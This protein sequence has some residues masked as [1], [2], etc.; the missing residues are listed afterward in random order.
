MKLEELKRKRKEFLDDTLKYYVKDPSRRAIVIA[1]KKIR[2][3]YKTTDGRKCAIGRHIAED[4]YD[5]TIEG[6]GIVCV[7]MASI[8]PKQIKNLGTPF[9]LKIQLLHDCDDNWNSQGLSD[10][11]KVIVGQI[12]DEFIV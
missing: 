12:E 9:L 2:C 7:K 3:M 6:L 1:D 5:S 4:K 8:I 11:G 10:H